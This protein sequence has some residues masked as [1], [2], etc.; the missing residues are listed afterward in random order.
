MNKENLF[1]TFTQI[2]HYLTFF[3]Y[4]LEIKLIT[5]LIKPC[6]DV[7]FVPNKPTLIVAVAKIHFIAQRNTKLNTG[8]ALTRRS[9]TKKRNSLIKLYKAL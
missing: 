2:K 1:N 4:I 8:K 9:A 3:R 5:I 7:K 6:V